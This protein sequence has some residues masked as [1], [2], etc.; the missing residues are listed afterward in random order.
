[1]IYAFLTKTFSVNPIDG[2]TFNL[3]LQDIIS[4]NDGLKSVR[5]SNYA[6]THIFFVCFS[7][8]DPKSLEN[9]MKKWIPEIIETGCP[10]VTTVLVGTK[11]DQRTNKTVVEELEKAGLKPISK[12]E[13]EKARAEIGADLYMECSSVTKEGLSQLFEEALKCMVAHSTKSKKMF[14][15][16]L[17]LEDSAPEPEE[18]EELPADCMKIVALGD[19]GVGKTS[20]LMTF[21]RGSLPDKIPT[22]FNGK[23]LFKVNSDTVPMAFTDMVGSDDSKMPNFA[24][25]HIFLLCF[26]LVDSQSLEHVKTKWIPVVTKAIQQFQ[27][28]PVV[29]VLVGTKLDQREDPNVVANLKKDG[30]SPVTQDEGLMTAIS[31]GI[32]SYVE[33]SSLT[34][35]GIQTV[36][37]T[38]ARKMEDILDSC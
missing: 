28:F 31:C 2:T 24:G 17:L 33:C 16:K 10:G 30:K 4:T 22:V 20:M 14:D 37:D 38:A 26:S 36:F 27:L 13:G 6:G 8:V 29:V 23:G 18:E 21:A 19:S 34:K 12:E 15:P 9:V 5:M 11:L 35:E 7:L 32:S 25:T 1:L 3:D